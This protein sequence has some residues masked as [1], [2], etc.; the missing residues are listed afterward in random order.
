MKLASRYAVD[1]WLRRAVL[2]GC[3]GWLSACAPKIGDSC[4]NSNDCSANGD[5]L[6]DTTQP[7]GYCTIFNCDPTNCPFDESLCV[8]FNN[9]VSTVGICP[10][11]HRP[12][13]YARTFCMA[14]CKKS[15]DCRAGYECTDLTEENPWGAEVVTK[16][17][18]SG[19]VCLWPI[20]GAEIEEDRQDAVCRGAGDAWGSEGGAAGGGG[21][22]P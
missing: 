7:G 16:K 12:S 21:E 6:C 13:P 8:A 15:S 17:S 1:R 4:N 10:D 18:N 22:R 20:S 19:K 14:R 11:P 5:R 9:V 3:L 2:F